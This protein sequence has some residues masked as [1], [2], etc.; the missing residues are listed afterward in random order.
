MKF[1]A[2]LTI[3]LLGI[4][5]VITVIVSYSVYTSSLKTLEEEVKDRL[6]DQAFHTMD[7]IDRT[8]YERFTDIRVFASDA[9]ISS[10]E[11]TPE[12]IT[13][14][15]IT[16]RNIYK[17]YSSLYFAD[18][19]GVK[20][21]ETLGIG[22]GKQHEMTKY[23]QEVLQGKISAAS[24]IYKSAT[25][26]TVDIH[27]ASSVKDENGEVFGIVVARM[28]VVK[29]YD[30]TKEAAGIHDKEKEVEIDLV[31][32]D[33]LLLYSNHNR[34]GIL[35]DNLSDYE[36]FKRAVAGERIGSMIHYDPILEEND[37]FVFVREQG[38]LDFEGN[39]WILLLHIPTKIIFAPAVQLRNRTIAILSVIIVLTVVISLI[40]ART[41]S[42]PLINLK[43][44]AVEIGK[45]KLD[46]RIEVASKDEIG[47]LAA[48]FNEMAFNL[49]KVT[50]SRDA[51]D[52][53]VA[54]R[55]RTEKE[56]QEA[57]DELEVRV[58]QRTAELARAN[59]EL[60]NEIGERKKTEEKLLSYQNQ[61]RSL[62]SEL[63]LAE[64][65]LRRRIA[66]DVHDHIGQNLA[67][68]KIKLDSL[69]EAISSS[70]L[71]GALE[72][73]RDLVAQTIES[74]R[75]L[76][77]KLSPP[78][79]YEL[80]F[81]P[82]MEWLVRETRQRHGLST[83]FTD[84]RQSKPLDNNIRV[85]L[86]QAVRELLVNVVKHAQARNVTV[87]TR[88]LGDE[89]CVS[90]ED[91]GVGFNIS[92]A[93][94]HEY[95]TEGFGLFSIRERLGHIGGHLDVESRDGKGTRVTLTAP[96]NQEKEKNKGKQK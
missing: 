23:W 86:F 48:S 15:L 59:E 69:A 22:I 70:E 25:T 91:D 77:F 7:K 85:L 78:V 53:E 66:T 35:K 90:V 8:L 68:S 62:A 30:I 46:T 9:I 51:L 38:Y 37:L 52:K 56:L 89:I 16:Y 12:E 94:S 5:T 83:E 42:R 29:L 87:S 40:F 84:D 13:E 74:A 24:D 65:R 82:A 39:D 44:A 27:F 17:T 50:A 88:R 3:L 34:R 4:T 14:R 26:G 32:K 49:N 11:S 72:E 73:I 67:I 21:A 55:N 96:I 63:S 61:L 81:E 1:A 57:R 33:G 80:G 41:I 79:L 54:E 31:N 28:P 64:E 58:E 2:K 75:S 47:E 93:G 71:S 92:E 19:N 6:E 18:L 36:S 95:R 45:G 10:R 43:N 60:R 20:I 76:T